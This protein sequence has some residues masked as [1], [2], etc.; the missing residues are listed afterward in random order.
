MTLSLSDVTCAF[1]GVKAVDS[2]SFDVYA[3]EPLGIVGPNGAGKTTL[4]NLIT[5]VLKPSKGEIRLDGHR[6]THR[7]ASR[8]CRLGVARTYQ[9]VRTFSSLSVLD[10]VA[11]AASFGSG[12][13]MS[14]RRSRQAAMDVI[15][16]LDMTGLADMR[17]SGLNLFQRKQVQLARALASRPSIL[18]LD[19]HL[20]GLHSNE[21]DGAVEQIKEVCSAFEVTPIVIEHVMSAILQLAERTIVLNAGR[22]M[23]DG[24]TQSVLELKE[25]R[26][27]YLGSARP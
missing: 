3:G 20:A 14:L 2:V 27:A 24:P 6:L 7:S 10:N 13:A 1:G 25:V 8:I 15:E 16:R 5:G 11:V 18:L 19:E 23:A 22:V 26:D 4:F 12:A 21:L 17:P 9:D